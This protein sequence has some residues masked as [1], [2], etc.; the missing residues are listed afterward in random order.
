MDPLASSPVRH[1]VLGVTGGIAAYKCAELVRLWVRQGHTVDVVMTAAAKAFVG[2]VTFQALS[3]RPVRDDL[4]HCEGG[5]MDHIALTRGVDALIVAPASADF[6]GKL[7]YGLADDLLSTLCL[8][9]DCPLLV[10]PAMNRQMWE[11]PA[12]RRNVAQLRADGVTVL[13]PASG[14]QA[15]GEVGEGRML[16]PEEIAW[17]VEAQ[18]LP[19]PLAGRRVLLTAGPT[20]ERIDPVRALINRSSGR[21][22]YA[23]AAA[24][25]DAGAAVTLVSG[26]VALPA[27][28]DVRVLRVE[29]AAQMLA[30]V[31][32]EVPG[33]DIF[34]SVAAVA[35][36]HCAQ[37]SMHKLKRDGSP[38]RLELAPNP[39]ILASVAARPDA[40]FCVGFAAESEDLLANAEAKRQRKRLPLLVANDASAIG[41]TES[42]LHLLD[43]AGVHSLPPADKT[44]S[45]RRVVEHVARLFNASRRHPQEAR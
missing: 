1:F 23:M 37:V 2:P 25:R 15:C 28:G 40:P 43:E 39:D 12:T 29:T 20:L 17:R 35:D 16:E 32:S 14:E 31:E 4:W 34:V 45:A 5:G 41:S 21:M 8:A 44:V 22:G 9:R 42:T 7:T 24:A 19:K 36:Y 27:P 11:N 30:A 10:A 38:L 3:G 6:I 33:A 13:G 26:P 18:L